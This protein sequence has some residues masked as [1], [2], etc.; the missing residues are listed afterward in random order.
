MAC[1][2]GVAVVV[3][4]GGSAGTWTGVEDSVAHSSR[5]VSWDRVAAVILLE[6]ASSLVKIA[7]VGFVVLVGVQRVRFS[8]SFVL[9]NFQ[10]ILSVCFS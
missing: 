6:V 8:L 2:R 9:L 4:V 10:R 7:C 5:V 1:N 3:V